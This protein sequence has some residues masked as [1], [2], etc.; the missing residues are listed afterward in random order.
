MYRVLRDKA[1]AGKAGPLRKAVLLELPNDLLPAYSEQP[2]WKN[3][4]S[5]GV[6]KSFLPELCNAK[7][8]V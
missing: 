8:D 7:H 1:T 6:Q 3:V 2:L 5:I 4:Y